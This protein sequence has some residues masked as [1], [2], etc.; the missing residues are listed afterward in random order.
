MNKEFI[1]VY[2][3]IILVSIHHFTIQE[4]GF[5]CPKRHLVALRCPVLR[6][7]FSAHQNFYDHY[8]MV[9][10]V[11]VLNE[12]RWAEY[13]VNFCAVKTLSVVTRIKY[14]VSILVAAMQICVV[15][16][17]QS[18]TKALH[19]HLLSEHVPHLQPL[20]ET[21]NTTDIAISFDLHQ[22]IEVVSASKTQRY[23]PVL[24]GPFYI[25]CNINSWY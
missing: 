5:Y 10:S 13:K 3:T 16:G 17:R 7:E 9:E 6:L 4:N 25:T 19:H 8:H 2:I 23:M 11:S 15:Q 20:K 18:V 12:Y 1:Y 14:S 24:C 22:L 21:T